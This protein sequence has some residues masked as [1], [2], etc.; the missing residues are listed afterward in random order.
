MVQHFVAFVMLVIGVLNSCYAFDVDVFQNPN[1][2]PLI[3]A[4]FI[5]DDD[6]TK[7]KAEEAKRKADEAR[8]QA[9]IR[10]RQADAAE[11]KR[12]ADAAEAKRQYRFPRSFL[13]VVV[14]TRC[15]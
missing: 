2:K 13:V 5:P 7:R 4:A 8:R 10:Q 1:Q 12:Q 15:L 11:A 14:A 3:L 9:A 6:A